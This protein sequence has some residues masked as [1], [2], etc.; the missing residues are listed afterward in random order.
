MLEAA[1]RY[2]TKMFYVPLFCSA[3]FI[4]FLTDVQFK[5]YLFS[6]CLLFLSGGMG[7]SHLKFVKATDFS[8]VAFQLFDSITSIY[9]LPNPLDGTTVL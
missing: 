1:E 3:N 9:P 5:I 6:L 8:R 7:K 4:W 2:R